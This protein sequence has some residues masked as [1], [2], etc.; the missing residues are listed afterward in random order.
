MG[1]DTGDFYLELPLILQGLQRLQEQSPRLRAGLRLAFS[2]ARGLKHI[3]SNTG[4]ICHSRWIRA[5]C[6]RWCKIA[7]GLT[8]D[9]WFGVRCSPEPSAIALQLDT[10][11]LTRKSMGSPPIKTPCIPVCTLVCKTASLPPNKFW[12]GPTN[13]ATEFGHEREATVPED[14]ISDVES[15]PETTTSDTPKPT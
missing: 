13:S 6:L 4:N 10:Q 1:F 5:W 12:S 11:E 3:Q 14:T 8:T 9:L 7:G 2:N 15:S